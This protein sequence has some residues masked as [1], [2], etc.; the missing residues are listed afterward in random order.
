MHI[1][2]VFFTFV[3]SF[4]NCGITKPLIWVASNATYGLFRLSISCNLDC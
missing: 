2:F 1:I 3:T 4:H